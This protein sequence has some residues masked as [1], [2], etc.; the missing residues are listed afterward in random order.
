MNESD[1]NVKCRSDL[2][3]TILGEFVMGDLSPGASF[4]RPS[5]RTRNFA[6]SVTAIDEYRLFDKETNIEI[7]VFGKE[8]EKTRIVSPGQNS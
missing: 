6:K 8:K 3:H 5:L 2:V 1:E 7:T 4:R